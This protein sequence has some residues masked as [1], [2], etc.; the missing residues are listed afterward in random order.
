MQNLEI[1]N[2]ELNFDNRKDGINHCIVCMND[3][4]YKL[5]FNNFEDICDIC[6]DQN[7][8]RCDACKDIFIYNNIDNYCS[9]CSDMRIVYKRCEKCKEYKDIKDFFIAK[10]W[11][12]PK[13]CRICRENEII[14]NEKRKCA[15]DKYIMY[16]KRG[17][18]SKP[19]IEKWHYTCRS[20]S[21]SSVSRTKAEIHLE[22][23]WHLKKAKK[24]DIEHPVIEYDLFSDEDDEDEEHKKCLECKELKDI[25]EY[26]N[27]NKKI[28][29]RC[30]DCRHKEYNKIKKEMESKEKQIDNS[31]NCKECDRLQKQWPPICCGNHN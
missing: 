11:F 4:D 3:K 16:E 19:E 15:F 6:Y 8:R 14:E 22:S 28:L 31:T 1:E 9:K 10:G 18:F 7:L 20:C 30:K 21:Y 12:I 23:D 2:T 25:N 29:D 13:E 26:L 5:N 17:I 27:S 24:Y